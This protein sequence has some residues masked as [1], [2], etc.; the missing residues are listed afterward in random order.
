MKKQLIILRV[1]AEE[2]EVAVY[3]HRTLLEVLREDIG[4]TGSKEG[5]GMG[6]CGACTVLVDAVFD[7]FWYE[8][9]F[10]VLAPTGEQ[11]EQVSHIDVA[12]FVGVAD[13]AIGRTG[14]PFLKHYQQVR[15][16]HCSITVDVGRTGM[17]FIR[18]HIDGTVPH[19]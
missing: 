16:I 19:T 4:L 2:H 5:C 11:R 8:S 1:N 10:T 3:P 14:T 9:S 6:A 17:P 13:A 12:V 7:R 15:H 18:A